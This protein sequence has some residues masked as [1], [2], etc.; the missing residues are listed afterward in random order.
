MYQALLFAALGVQKALHLDQR[1]HEALRV[2]A[3]QNAVYDA[4]REVQVAILF[5]AIL[6]LVW[7]VRQWSRRERLPVE[8]RRIRLL[9]FLLLGLDAIRAV[10]LHQ[11]DQ[12]LFA[13]VGRIHLNHMLEGGLTALILWSTASHLQKRTQNNRLN[14]RQA[15]RWRGRNR[16]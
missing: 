3:S 14:R 5:V 9:G 12:I 11:I 16:F 13:S 7:V 10:S 2:M 1:V 15:S 8:L 6:G 4:R